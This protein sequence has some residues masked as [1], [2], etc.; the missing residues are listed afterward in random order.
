MPITR[1]EDQ[2]PALLVKRQLFVHR[3]NLG[4]ELLPTEAIGHPLRK[5]RALAFAAFHLSVDADERGEAG[6]ARR[7][8]PWLE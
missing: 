6:E 1:R 4:C 7:R 8:K 5:L 2:S 3:G